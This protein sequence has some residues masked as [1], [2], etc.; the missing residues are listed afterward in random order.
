VSYG[1]GGVGPR[2]GN[3]TV[4]LRRRKGAERSGTRSGKDRKREE[5]SG[6]ELCAYN[7]IYQAIVGNVGGTT[8]KSKMW[9]RECRRRVLEL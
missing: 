2:Y 1:G 4:P 3:E 5:R 6:K 8:A 9:K 7:I